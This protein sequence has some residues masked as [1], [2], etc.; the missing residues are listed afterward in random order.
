MKE[1]IAQVFDAYCQA[2]DKALNA[3]GFQPWLDKRK[4]IHESN[5]VHT[6]LETY[7]AIGKNIITWMELPVSY[8]GG[9]LKPQLAHIDGFIADYDR[10]RIIFI[11]AK[12]FSRETQF[13][14]LNDDIRR[15]YDIREEIYVGD[16]LFKGINLFDY[17]AYVLFLADIWEHR[18]AWA[19]D[20]AVNWNDSLKDL[21]C[22]PEYVMKK[23]IRQIIPGY[24]LTY[25]LA[26]FFRAEEYR[27]E[28]AVTPKKKRKIDPSLLV[29]SDEV[30]FE[31]LL[32]EVNQSG[33]K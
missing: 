7:K 22:N 2:Y 3:Q 14:S 11:E 6:F 33:K 16:S 24:H 23:D 32:A 21:N 8:K 4:S 20:L 17:D 31:C 9:Y 12:R 29:W 10:K 28:L 27:K 5:Q 1:F 30:G 18:N 26:P 13:K 19:K 15:L 25:T